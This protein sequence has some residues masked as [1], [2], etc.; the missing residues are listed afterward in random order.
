MC[1]CLSK[2]GCKR[3]RETNRV[4]VCVRVYVRV[5]VLEGEF[6]FVNVCKF[7]CKCVHLGLCGHVYFEGFRPEWYISTIYHCSDIPF[8]SETLDLCVCTYV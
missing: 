4:C 7:V 3:Q 5:C 8:W 2:C 1:V 6:V